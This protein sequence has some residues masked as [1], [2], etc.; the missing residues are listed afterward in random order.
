[1][2]ESLPRR[3]HLCL[4]PRSLI[5]NRNPCENSVVKLETWLRALPYIVVVLL[6]G[7]AIQYSNYA[8][9]RSQRHW[10]SLVTTMDNTYSQAPPTTETGK[11]I[12]ADIRHLVEAFECERK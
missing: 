8:I 6:F 11:Q 4:N 3:N 7:I 12:A 2:V 10:C 9:M 5:R 1:M